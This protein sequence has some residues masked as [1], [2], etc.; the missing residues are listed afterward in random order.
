MRG[1]V[2]FGDLRCTGHD[3]GVVAGAA[4]D[5]GLRIVLVDVDDDVLGLDRPDELHA[6]D[7]VVGAFAHRADRAHG[8]DLGVEA[9]LALA[10]GGLDLAV[11]A[12][13]VGF[14]GVVGFA[15]EEGRD[16][17]DHVPIAH[18]AGQVDAVDGR[19]RGFAVGVESEQGGGSQ[20]DEQG[21]DE[22]FLHGVAP[23]DEGAASGLAKR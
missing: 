13:F 23:E 19:D 14:D 12:Q 5:D 20:C 4:A 6:P 22:D 18:E 10:E 11:V 3:P 21:G 16:I 2:G 15:F 1:V 8:V 9:A 17:G 7:R